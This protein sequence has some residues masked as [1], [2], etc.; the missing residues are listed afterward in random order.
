MILRTE[1]LTKSFG[2]LTAVNHVN[3]K[4]E[5]GGIHSIIGPNGAGKTTLFNLLTGEVAPSRGQVYFQDRK[6]TG[7]NPYQIARIRIGRSFQQNKIFRNLTVLENLRLASH[8]HMTGRFNIFRHFRHF[9]QPIDRAAKLLAEQGLTDISARRA[10]ELSH[11]QQRTMEVAMALAGD[12]V[13]LLLDEPTSGMS[14]EDSVNM[15]R[16]LEKLGRRLTMVVIEHNMNL[17]MSISSTITVLNQGM[18]LATGSPQEIAR[19]EQVRTAYLG[20]QT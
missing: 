9:E 15:I 20:G 3:L 14:P 12:P 17:V 5:N 8:A 19:N 4:V 13:L 6:I 1:D 11:G 16:L 7:L 2:G 10:G 18:I